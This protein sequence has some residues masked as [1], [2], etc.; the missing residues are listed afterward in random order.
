MRR[1]AVLGRPRYGKKITETQGPGKEEGKPR[2]APERLTRFQRTMI[3][4]VGR[5]RGRGRCAGDTPS[6]L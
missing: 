4:L 2:E 5:P 6:R 3:A 1:F